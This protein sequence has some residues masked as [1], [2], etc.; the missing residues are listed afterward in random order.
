MRA[1]RAPN[2]GETA[3]K[4]KHKRNRHGGQRNGKKKSKDGDE[5]SLI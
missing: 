5:T 2:E 4:K 3:K 1:G